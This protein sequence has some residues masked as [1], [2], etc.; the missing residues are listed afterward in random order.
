M[1]VK[2]TTEAEWLRDSFAYIYMYMCICIVPFKQ[3]QKLLRKP[4]KR[5]ILKKY[6]QIWWMTGFVF[7]NNI[8]E[9]NSKVY[10]QK[11]GRA[12]GTKFTCP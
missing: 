3:V 11:S 12:I 9:F 4:S 8:F 1:F 10:E 7:D 6:L 5:E 2:A